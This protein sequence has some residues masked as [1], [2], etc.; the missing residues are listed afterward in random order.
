MIGKSLLAA[1]LASGLVL[2]PETG[3]YVPAKPAIVKPENLD[4]S[5]NMLAMPMLVGAI[6]PQSGPPATLSYVTTY[7][8]NMGGL[9]STSATG[10]PV[11]AAA[12]NRTI[13]FILSGIATTN[14]AN[15]ANSVTLSG[16]AMTK[17]YELA[18]SNFV[19][20]V[21][22]LN[23]ASGISKTVNAAFTTPQAGLTWTIYAAYGL[24]SIV[25]TDISA[26]WGANSL[27]ASGFNISRGGIAIGLAM[28]NL[29][30]GVFAWSGLTF[31]HELSASSTLKSSTAS[32]TYGQ[33]QSNLPLNVNVTTAGTFS[34]ALYAAFR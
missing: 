19:C 17:Q 26:A 32:Q 24:Q 5:K 14:V 10:V 4:F 9:A 8:S 1:T 23:N 16:A 7:R 2:P 34:T 22:T 25:P 13:I 33:A 31:N 21:F 3:L 18:V 6:K 29:T 12:A 28:T 11:G 20:A 27:P 15:S 30:T